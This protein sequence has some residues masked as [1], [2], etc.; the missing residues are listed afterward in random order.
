MRGQ[1]KKVQ[2]KGIRQK[3]TQQK[4]MWQAKIHQKEELQEE[5]WVRGR[6]WTNA[7]GQ[8]PQAPPQARPRAE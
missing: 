4:G 7:R 2:R 1:R 3:G 8:A 6:C 5:K